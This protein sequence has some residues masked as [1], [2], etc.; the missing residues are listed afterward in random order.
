MSKVPKNENIVG[1]RYKH[2]SSVN[3]SLGTLREATFFKEMYAHTDI[4]PLARHEDLEALITALVDA[5]VSM[6]LAS[7]LPGVADEYDFS[8]PIKVAMIALERVAV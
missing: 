6:E 4:E 8:D 3:W 5:L 1:Y 2:R 7:R